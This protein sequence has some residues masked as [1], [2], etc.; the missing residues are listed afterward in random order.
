MG[1]ERCWKCNGKRF[2]ICPICEGKRVSSGGMPIHEYER[3]ALGMGPSLCSNCDGKGVVPCE[4]CEGK[5]YTE[6]Y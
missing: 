6:T 2:D 3:R 4:V 1:K 5:G